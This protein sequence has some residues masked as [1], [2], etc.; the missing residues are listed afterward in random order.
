MKRKKSHFWASYADL[1]TSLFFLMVILFIICIVELKNIGITP[2]ELAR[3]RFELD[4]VKTVNSSLG[5]RLERTNVHLDSM[6]Y[7]VNATQEQI[8]KVNEINGA[9]ENLDPVFFVYDSLH[10]KHKLNFDVKFK[11]EDDAITSISRI[12][13]EKLIAEAEE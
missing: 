11:I 2:E 1:M 9:T 3:L 10:K 12:E 5:L 6:T 8:D 7:W 4:S 13:R